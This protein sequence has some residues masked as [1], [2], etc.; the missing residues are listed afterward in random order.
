MA[1]HEITVQLLPALAALLHREVAWHRRF[2]RSLMRR[3]WTDQKDEGGLMETLG[4]II[5]IAAPVGGI[6]GGVVV[7]RYPPPRL[8][9]AIV[10]G[11]GWFVGLVRLADYLA[12]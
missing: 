9:V 5:S 12:P 8:L 7:W 1:D 4:T 3:V 6:I 10:V 2:W 11:L